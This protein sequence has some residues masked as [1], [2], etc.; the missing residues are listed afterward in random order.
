MMLSTRSRPVR[1]RPVR[2]QPTESQTARPRATPRSR[3]LS[4]VAIAILVAL[5]LAGLSVLYLIQTSEVVSLGYQL[6]RLQNQHDAVELENSRLRYQI[7]TYQ[8]LDRIERMARDELG[9][10][11]VRHV[12]YLDVA[13]PAP[14]PQPPSPSLPAPSFWQRVLDVLMGVG[15]ATH[16][17]ATGA[18]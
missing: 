17:S 6:T 12:E 5:A 10:A 15:R 11:P 1:T 2:P 7:A 14:L 13:R 8:A 16:E 3:R 18:S 4:T 9:M